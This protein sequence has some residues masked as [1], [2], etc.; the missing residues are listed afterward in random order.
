MTLQCVLT[1]KVQYVCTEKSEHT[2]EKTIEQ[3]TQFTEYLH[4]YSTAK[5]CHKLHFPS[6]HKTFDI[7]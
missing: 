2:V 5:H 3:V 1:M 4:L 6:V 7:H